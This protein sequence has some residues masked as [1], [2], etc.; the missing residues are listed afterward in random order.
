MLG[1][2]AEE[3]RCAVVIIRHLTKS[4]K[5]KASYRG[6]GSID[7]TAAARSVL[8][9]GKD[10]DDE[11]KR[12]VVQTKSSLAETGKSIAFA[13]NDGKF[14]WLGHTEVTA[15]VLAPERM[16]VDDN[17]EGKRS[18][19]SEARKYLIN[20]LKDGPMLSEE[21]YAGIKYSGF[22]KRT[23]EKAKA[24]LKIKSYREGSKWFW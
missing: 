23:L 2:L 8:L 16:E 18:P 24:E 20:L 1:K 14:E 13:I 5:D 9:V 12:V 10:P 6:M 4:G 3:F 21:I 19:I 15:Q 11:T 7:F 22:K 17:V